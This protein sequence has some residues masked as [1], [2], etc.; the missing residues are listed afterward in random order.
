VSDSITTGATANVVAFNMGDGAT[1]LQP[2]SGA[3]NVLSLG[4][5]I[6]TENLF[7]TKSAK[8]LILTDGVGGDS[9]TF[10]NWYVGAADQNYTTLQV[11]E[12]ASAN[13]NSAGTDGL[14]NKAL[15]AFNLTALVGAYNAAGSPANWALSTAMATTQLASTSTADYGGDLAYYF[16]LN[17]NLTGM[18]LSA[19]QS[20]LTNASFGT[21]TQTIDAFSSISGGG[22]LHLAVVPPERLIT[23]IRQPQFRDG[24][25]LGI[26]T[27]GSISPQ[28]GLQFRPAGETPSAS[29]LPALS[30]SP[31][32]ILPTD[33]VSAATDFATSRQGSANRETV[34]PTLRSPNVRSLSSSP[35]IEQNSELDVSHV[36][37]K[38]NFP[39]LREGLAPAVSTIQV[40]AMSQA[41]SVSPT[42]PQLMDFILPTG[43]TSPIASSQ[44]AFATP[45]AAS[46]ITPVTISDVDAMLSGAETRPSVNP[47]LGIHWSQGLPRSF[48]DPVNVAWLT[49]HSAL[50]QTNKMPIGGSEASTEHNE[51][52]NDALAAS[53]P[54]G[55]IRRLPE[56]LGIH[57]PQSHQ[58]AL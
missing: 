33:P 14:R 9:I 58:R 20:T 36:L 8:N 30:F 42:S 4:A 27:L 28:R 57:S 46:S 3:S 21:A 2:T 25:D 29:V 15:E 7:F 56:E 17:G 49:M 23:A 48:V 55:R 38:G 54:L 19:A 34:E 22:G 37:N 50:D 47:K 13:Y 5:G 43:S 12:I 44:P 26:S 39:Q 53:A 31:T 35:N 51:V 6:D 41:M 52:A 45:R 32:A 11:V 10:T 24:E 1:T 16:G 40:P 18:N